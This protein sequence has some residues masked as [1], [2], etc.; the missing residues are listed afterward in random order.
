MSVESSIGKRLIGLGHRPFIIAELSGN[1]NK[2]LERAYQIVD[3]AAAGTEAITLPL[4]PLL[5]PADQQ[6][7]I[8]TLFEIFSS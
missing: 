2:P 5:R 4:Y 1:H 6:T 7:V 3:A 8:D